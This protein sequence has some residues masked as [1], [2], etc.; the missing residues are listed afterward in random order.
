MSTP[1]ENYPLSSLKFSIESQ[2]DMEQDFH[3]TTMFHINVPNVV[4]HT[5]YN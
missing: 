2:V 4:M 3:Q 5:P 1:D